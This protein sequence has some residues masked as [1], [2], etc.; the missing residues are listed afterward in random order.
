MLCTPDKASGNASPRTAVSCS[1]TT[2]K[3][4]SR[5]R[6]VIAK[7]GVPP[8]SI[9]TTWRS[10]ATHA[11]GIRVCRVGRQDCGR[12]PGATTATSKTSRSKRA[13]GTCRGAARQQLVN[14]LA[15][16]YEDAMLYGALAT[17]RNGRT[18]HHVGRRIEWKGPRA[19]RRRRPTA[20]TRTRSSAH[21]RL[22]RSGSRGQAARQ[23][24]EFGSRR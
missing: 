8:S 10:W 17:M 4:P 9:P 22:L 19:D 23:S 20:S 21:R 2:P 14:A 12:G 16:H 15:A 7:F 6:G 11:D 1:S 5:L 24:G 13:S 18:D 3:K